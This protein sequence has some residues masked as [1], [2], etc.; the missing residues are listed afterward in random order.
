VQQEG[1]RI[2]VDIGG[3]FT[4]LVVLNERA[5][6]VRT[7]K[8]PSTPH[9]PSQAV[10]NAVRRLRG[11]FGIDLSQVTQFTHA[12][13]VACNT[14]L[15]GTGARTGLLVTDG[16][17]DVLQIQRH[18]R[19]RLFDLAYKKIAP[20]VPR[21]LI[22]GIPERIDAAG[23]VVRPLDEE[24][25]VA[26]VEALGR[27]GVEALAICFLFSF[28][29]A[30]HERRTAEIAREILPDVF[31]TISSDVL[32]QYREYERTSTTSVNGLLGPRMSRYLRNM[33]G[34][35]EENGIRAP[36]HLMQSNGGVLHWQE[37]S[38]MPCRI[39]E[40]G[41]A[42]GVIAAAHFGAVAGRKHLIA[43]DMG[44]TTA[45]AGLVENGD[46][47]QSDGQEVG[48]GINISRVLQGGGYYIGA[49]TVDLAEVGAGGGSIAWL[50]AAGMLKVG[51]RS[52]GAD[53]GP[54]AYGLGGE[55]VTVTDANLLLGRIPADHFLGGEMQLDVERARRVLENTIAKPLGVSVDD[56][57]AAIIEVANASMLKMLRIVTVEKGL[58]P[59]D[60][61]LVAFGGN[62]PVFGV[63]L[64]DDLGMR[65]VIIPP[66][67]GL[68]SAQ[69]LLAADLRYYF[70]QTFVG[71]VASADLAEI[72]GRFAAL[73]AQ[74]RNALQSHGIGDAAIVVTRTA[75]M[76]Y[77]RQ[78]YEL[79]VPLPPGA[80]SAATLPALVESFHQ[81]HERLYGRRDAAG[82]VEIVNL[83][84]ALTGNVTRP[85]YREIAAGDGSA[86]HASKGTRNVFFANR[87]SFDCVCYE[88]PQLRAGD[89]LQGPA[90]VEAADSTTLLPPDWSLRCDRIGNL[91]ATRSG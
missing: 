89:S 5:G 82:A 86:A 65:E 12:T 27:E 61:T 21:H 10:L 6:E 48:A 90:I 52:A 15:E 79:N 67:P 19:Y 75:D 83:C 9:D 80:L 17:R 70:R 30:T 16:F 40:S 74:G 38:R 64:A 58:D 53:P 13:T 49:P 37:A 73:E 76:R 31:V 91:F 84:V 34:S 32:P 1:F 8:V 46:V 50:D 26:A 33:N 29:N 39:V 11:E 47:R 42:A 77:R 55:S 88:R 3:T 36:L 18:K 56:A 14:I 23:A 45:K 68:L 59:A 41:P 63:E 20:L 4:D 54:I 71:A 87:G 72:E 24:A 81:A 66:A 60:F 43:F 25:V 51:P 69:G 28:R 22:Y 35:L 44:G 2:G 57:C 85:E 7:L 62:G 78:A